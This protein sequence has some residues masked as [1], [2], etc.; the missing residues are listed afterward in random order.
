LCFFSL[1]LLI[2]YFVFSTKKRGGRICPD[3]VVFSSRLKCSMGTAVKG[4][5]G[6]KG[7]DSIAGP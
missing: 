7:A 3:Q 2:V 6:T 5:D 1:L 4:H